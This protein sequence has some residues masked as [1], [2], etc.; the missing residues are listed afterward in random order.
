[1]TERDIA[2][3]VLIIVLG[4]ACL[5][6]SIGLAIKSSLKWWL[7][8]ICWTALLMIAFFVF[9][10]GLDW[11]PDSAF[12]IAFADGLDKTPP[13]FIFCEGY[14]DG[15]IKQ[16]ISVWTDLAFMVSGL[17][18]GLRLAL[19][20][21][22]DKDRMPMQGWG[23]VSLMYVLTVIYMGPGSMYYHA[24][25]KDW[26]G[27]SDWFSII[28]WAAFGLAF[29][30]WRMLRKQVGNNQ[31]PFWLIWVA[32]AVI[33]GAIG[34][35]EPAREAIRFV[36]IPLWVISELVFLIWQAVAKAKKE[37]NPFGV[38]RN[39]WGWF[40]AA[41]LAFIFAFAVWI[42]SGG[43]FRAWCNADSWFQGHGCWHILAALGTYFVYHFW[44]TESKP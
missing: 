19:C 38:V 18:I 26:A 33:T 31:W 29:T 41:V 6:L 34:L 42:P 28:N 24:S 21:G 30:C 36:I 39:K 10:L 4:G 3:I 9:G 22:S 14:V 12:D 37:E 20:S 15:W 1:M 13:E 7:W 25:L 2:S 27:W 11:F 32:V 16:P 17:A 44:S 5:G 35:Y 40:L 23:I 43:V 8:P